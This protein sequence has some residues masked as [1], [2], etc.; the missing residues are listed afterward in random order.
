ME[1]LNNFSRCERNEGET[2]QE[3]H[4]LS[5]VYDSSPGAIPQTL[6]AAVGEVCRSLV[7][8]EYCYY[9][10]ALPYQAFEKRYDVSMYL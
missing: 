2:W 5:L 4:A 3:G 1:V 10:L 8:E 6:K 7:T 9:I